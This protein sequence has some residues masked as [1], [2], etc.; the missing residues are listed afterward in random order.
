[1]IALQKTNS[2]YP[3]FT[4]SRLFLFLPLFLFFIVYEGHATR[5][6]KA[7]QETLKTFRIYA[8]QHQLATLPVN[9]RIPVIA[10]FF[11]DV[12]YKSNTL[13]VT[14]DELPVINLQ[15][16]DCVTFVEN[17]LALS[18]LPSY[19]D[20]SSDAFVENIVKLRY[21]NG[22]IEDYA[23]RLHYSS[24]WLYEMQGQHFLT[25]I[26][27]FAGGMSFQPDIYFMS[28]NYTRYPPIEK[29]KK[30]LAKIKAIETAINKRTYY[31]IPK[32]KINEAC[33]KI[34]DGDV[35]LITTNIKGLDTSHL[36]FALK[37]GGKTYLLHA[38]SKGKKVMISE[39]PLQEYMAG[40]PSQSG[41]MLARAVKTLPSQLL[42]E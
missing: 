10:R 16:L 11:L 33:N 15:E 12:P 25:D 2:N 42:P 22:E 3:R 21:R 27:Q 41:I 31:Y 37:Q 9:E 23:S 19:D 13:N 5:I 29:D 30:L 34:K 6:S 24:D 35:I 38:S 4:M 26:T 20:Q 17:V 18:Y 36:G 1:M 40:N 32:V 7:D 8:N 14:K 39:T 28:K